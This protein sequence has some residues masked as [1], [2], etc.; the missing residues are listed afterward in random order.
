MH[1]PMLNKAKSSREVIDTFL[2]YNHNLKIR[3]GELYTTKNMSTQQY[4]LLAN[5]PRRGASRAMWWPTSWNDSAAMAGRG[6][7][8]APPFPVP[9]RARTQP[10]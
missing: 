2:G 4:P 7:G 8:H 5:R 10:A 3:D 9:S 6:P 1:Y